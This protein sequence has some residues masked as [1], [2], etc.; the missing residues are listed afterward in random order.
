ME[1][2]IH[3]HVPWIAEA[4]ADDLEVFA[5]GIATKHATL[6]TPVVRGIMVGFTVGLR[7]EC[8]GGWQVGRAF[9]RLHPPKIAEW[10]GRNPSR[11]REPLGVAL[12]H[13]ELAVRAPV[14]SVQGVLNVAEVG[15]DSDVFIC[16]IIA[17]RVADDGE[18]RRVGHVQVVSL[19]QQPVNAVEAVGERLSLIR[20][21]IVIVVDENLDRVARCVFLG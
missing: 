4:A 18:V 8:F 1:P 16:D 19:P 6:A 17:V 9:R 13:V 3:R 7:R 21:T 11:L 14:E 20:D 15:V 10:L 12:G 5:H 2:V